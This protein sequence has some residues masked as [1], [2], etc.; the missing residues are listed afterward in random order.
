MLVRRSFSI[1]CQIRTPAFSISGREGW[2]SAGVNSPVRRILP[3]KS[4]AQSPLA[5][6]PADGDLR[7]WF[8]DTFPLKQNRARR[9]FLP[10]S[11]AWTSLTRR[12]ER[13][14]S[15]FCYPKR[16]GAIG[17]AA[18]AGSRLGDRL[19]GSGFLPCGLLRCAGFSALP[20]KEG[21]G[22]MRIEGEAP[23]GLF[24]GRA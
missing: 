14:E 4:G 12:A 16:R 3:K 24:A 20:A 11:P 1:I 6:L 23:H 13:C 19:L 5:G 2:D 9:D 10:A 22:I 15:S 18:P 8:L 21:Q 7:Y 17:A